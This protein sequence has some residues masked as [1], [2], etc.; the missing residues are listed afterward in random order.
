MSN[1]PKGYRAGFVRLGDSGCLPAFLPE[2]GR[3][4]NGFA[5]PV[6]APEVV[7]E[8]RATLEAMFSRE[9]LDERD[10]YALTWDDDGR[11]HLD[12]LHYDDGADDIADIDIDGTR[13]LVIGGGFVWE[14][15]E[16]RVF[17]WEDGF[18]PYSAT[19]EG[20]TLTEYAGDIARNPAAKVERRST[21]T[22]RPEWDD[23]PNLHD[24]AMTDA[25]SAGDV[26][27]ADAVWIDDLG[28]SV[29]E[30]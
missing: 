5:L 25:F 8:H 14:E 18:T 26:D 23:H 9:G 19:L 21:L 27:G 28:Y 6:F 12:D 22:R 1:T 16:S 29:E 15:V 7:T 2:D 13:F 30:L 11:P 17:E 10:G 3:T 4:W 24:Y 20:D